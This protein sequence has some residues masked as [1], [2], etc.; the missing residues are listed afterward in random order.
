[1][2]IDKACTTE[3]KAGLL[4]MAFAVT[5]RLGFYSLLRPGELLALSASDIKIVRRPTCAPVVVIAIARPKTAHVL[6]AGKVQV[7]TT[8]D[9]G[10]VNWVSFYLALL[11]PRDKLWPRSRPAFNQHFKEALRFSGM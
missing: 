6:G 5:T 2:C 3:G 7:A 8:S 9:E 11:S 4:W 10:T 1:M